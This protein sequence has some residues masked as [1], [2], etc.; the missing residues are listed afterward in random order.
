V[1][2]RN[3]S[4]RYCICSDFKR[5]CVNSSNINILHFHLCRKIPTSKRYDLRWSVSYMRFYTKRSRRQKIAATFC[6]D[7][8]SKCFC[9]KSFVTSHHCNEFMYERLPWWYCYFEREFYILNPWSVGWFHREGGHCVTNVRSPSI[10][11]IPSC[12]CQLWKMILIGSIV[13]A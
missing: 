13:P 7:L 11:I 1:A 6:G 4:L 2:L 10:T 5:C 3:H 9:F 12:H 8:F